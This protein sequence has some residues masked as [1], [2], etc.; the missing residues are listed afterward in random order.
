MT[1]AWWQRGDRLSGLSALVSGQRRRRHRR[2]ARASRARLDHLAWLGRRRAV[3]LADLSRRRWRISATT[4]PITAASTRCSARSADFDALI[5]AAHARGL[6]L[7]LDFVPNH[8]LRPASLV[9][10]EPRGARTARSATGII[11]RDAAPGGGP[12]NNWLSN[13]GGRA[14]TWDAATR[15]VLLPLVPADAAGPELAQSRRCARP[16]STCCGSG[17]GAAWTG[18]AST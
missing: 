3:D 16:C 18:S 7:I 6:K 14:W 1:L 9:P 4:S 10:R 5:A 8:T 17:C 12:P 11:W 2:P 15:P 13:F